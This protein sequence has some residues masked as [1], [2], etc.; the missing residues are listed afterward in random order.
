MNT[1]TPTT[2]HV[3]RPPRRSA[4]SLMPS[5]VG[6]AAG[7]CRETVGRHL[8]HTEPQQILLK[9]CVG[10]CFATAL[11]VTGGIAFIASPETVPLIPSAFLGMAVGIVNWISG[12]SADLAECERRT[13]DGFLRLADTFAEEI[14][15]LQLMAAIKNTFHAA[16]DLE[17]APARSGAAAGNERDRKQ[18][19]PA[20]EAP[21]VIRP[22][23]PDFRRH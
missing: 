19:F 16:G 15:R 12:L 11:T 2:P 18:P 4:T 8:P 20:A 17:G 3:A 5:V 1:Q 23:F 7:F 22:Q 13:N 14:E 21:N 9:G 10:A 6:T